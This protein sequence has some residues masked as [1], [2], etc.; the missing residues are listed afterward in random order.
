MN[1]FVNADGDT[2]TLN[3]IYSKKSLSP[4]TIELQ[5]DRKLNGLEGLIFNNI[6]SKINAGGELNSYVIDSDV[7]D[8]FM[9]DVIKGL[10]LNGWK[11][12]LSSSYLV[13]LGPEIITATKFSF[14]RSSC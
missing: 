2:Y 6:H 10:R 12:L 3:V 13:P 9:M 4:S 14:E 8:S 5:L 1:S 11:L 7:N